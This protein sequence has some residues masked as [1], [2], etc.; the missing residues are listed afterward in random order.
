MSTSVRHLYECVTPHPDFPKPGI[1]SQSLNAL[2]ASP[3]KFAHLAKLMSKPFKNQA[4]DVVLGLQTGGLALAS[5]VAVH[6][7][8][9]YVAIHNA[10]DK[11]PC[12]Y[13]EQS[14]STEDSKDVLKIEVGII[15]SYSRVLIVGDLFSTAAT[16]KAAYHLLTNPINAIPIG[17]VCAIELVGVN[18]GREQLRL[19]DASLMVRSIMRFDNQTGEPIFEKEP[20]PFTG[21][22]IDA[23]SLVPTQVNT[24]IV[25][26]DVSEGLVFYYPT[27][28]DVAQK[29]VNIR[30]SCS[31]QVWRMA[32]IDWSAFPNGMPNLRIENIA[33]IQNRHIVFIADLSDVSRVLQQLIV[34]S[35]LPKQD[36]KSFETIIPFFP[37]GTYERVT[38][39]GEIAS[40]DVV[41][42]FLTQR[43]PS[44]QGGIPR[45]SILDIHALANRFYFDNDVQLRL[46]HTA[47]PYILKKQVIGKYLLD[48]YCDRPVVI[49][50]PDDGA[51]KRFGHHFVNEFPVITFNKVRDGNERR[52]TLCENT[53]P[54][55]DEPILSPS[56]K[57]PN[58]I[59]VLLVDD[60][61]LSGETL[62]KCAKA[63]KEKYGAEKVG[64]FFTHAVFPERAY[65]RFCQG[66]SDEGLFDD[67]F[68]TD[69]VPSVAANLDAVGAP[70]VVLSCAP[71]LVRDFTF[72]PN[73]TVKEVCVASES[74][75]KHNAAFDAFYH[76]SLVTGLGASNFVVKNLK[77]KS[78]VP[79]Q[80]YGY[81]EIWYGCARRMMAL[82]RNFSN[83]GF[84][85][86]YVSAENGI[87]D[88][89]DKKQHFDLACVAVGDFTSGLVTFQWSKQYSIPYF[90][91]DKWFAKFGSD[92]SKTIGQMLHEEDDSVPADNWAA[93]L[94]GPENS[95]QRQLASA[96]ARAIQHHLKLKV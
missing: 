14:Y 61:A 36:V 11:L 19:L 1:H 52:V 49:A 88:S 72:Y 73:K 31:K 57:L 67:I 58:G 62:G 55:C 71:A 34:I 69:S 25:L 3:E 37:F 70:F 9:S 68:T 5:A 26:N 79:E 77:A 47:A 20:N 4:I 83:L 12:P 27:M 44:T 90:V 63:L 46:D 51:K 86:W 7:K 2:L 54:G 32:E 59:Y 13:I 35:V 23:D 80:P 29:Y 10:S 56:N 95:R 92:Q 42:K 33:A 84:E 39:E 22:T 6:L 30:A 15:K 94:H 81:C 87:C 38:I 75:I 60:Q 50:M 43:L 53:L 24:K 18:N 76:S 82:K 74:H 89:N 78:G 85:Q 40:A 96:I 45:L 48:T 16:I 64:C 93:S 28:A 8:A 65:K 21:S 41:S 91:F 17:F 66:G